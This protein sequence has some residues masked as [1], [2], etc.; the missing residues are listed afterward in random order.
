MILAV[1]MLPARSEGQTTL[2]RHDATLSIGWSGAEYGVEDYDRWRGSLLL[3]VGV[4][5]YWTDHLKTEIEAG[6]NS[7]SNGEIYEEVIVGGTP[8]YGL[9]NYRVGDIKLSLGQTY[10]F[11]RNEWVHPF[12]GA[13]IDVIRRDTVFDRPPQNRPSYGGPNQRPI[14]VLVPPR[15]ESETRTLARPF[16]KAGWK[17]Y[18]SDRVYFSTE[19][20]LGFAPDLDHAV[21]KLG[22]GFDF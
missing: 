18:A 13:G 1:V 17:M 2:P 21:W 12:V 3:G 19:F 9:A 7:R 14:D 11:G 20:K 22:L 5:R 8:A 15:H 10:Q 4:G 16:I 6:W